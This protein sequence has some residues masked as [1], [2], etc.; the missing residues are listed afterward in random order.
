MANYK[1]NIGK[2]RD[3]NNRKKIDKTIWRN[4][5][6]LGY[7]YICS[8]QKNNQTIKSVLT[9]ESHDS[10][11]DGIWLVISDTNVPL[12]KILMEAKYRSDYEK[13]LPLS[14]CAKAIIIAFNM[15]ANKLYIVTN[16]AFAPQTRSEISQF[17]RRSNL[18]VI[19][20]NQTELRCFISDNRDDLIKKF[21][22]DEQFLNELEMDD[23]PKISIPDTVLNDVSKSYLFDECRK[24]LI[25]E[26]AKKLMSERAVYM[27]TGQ[28]GIGKSILGKEIEKRLLK[29]KYDV[30]KI[31]LSLCTSARVLYLK[32]LEAI[33]GVSLTT[34]LEDIDLATYLDQLISTSS[35]TIEPA[36]VNAIK[37]ILTSRV[38][39]AEHKDIFLYLLLK[40]IDCILENKKD[41]LNLAIFFENINM[42]SEEVSDFLLELINCLRKNNIK[43]LLEV[44]TPFIFVDNSNLTKSNWYF[45]SLKKSVDDY[46]DVKVLESKTAIQM[47]QKQLLLSDRVCSNMAKTLDN[48]PL[49]IQSALK[50]LSADESLLNANL[51]NMSDEQ[52]E[53]YW[54]ECGISLNSVVS[55][56]ILKLRNDPTLSYAFEMVTL[57]KGSIPYYVLN[58]IDKEHKDHFIKAIEDSTIFKEGRAAFECFHLRYLTAMEETSELRKKYE[59]ALWLLPIVRENKNAN[60]LNSYI[61]LNLLY[62]LGMDE[63][64]PSYTLSVIALLKE[65]HQYKDAIKVANKYIELQDAKT[66]IDTENNKVMIDVLIQTLSCVKELDE[67]NNPAYSF[68]YKKAC[69]YIMLDNPDTETAGRN[70]YQFRLLLWF[71]EF[72]IGHFDEAM[73]IAKSLYDQIEK[74]SG[75]FREDED[76]PGQVYN[77]YG[78]SVK[79]KNSGDAAEQIFRE[80][81]SRYPKSFFGRA[82]LLSQVGNRLL[83]TEPLLAAQI[84]ADLL[85]TIKG[86]DYPYQECLHTRIDIAMSNF[87]GEKYNIACMRCK[88]SVEIASTI[89]IYTQKGRALNIWGCCLAAQGDYEKSESLFRESY[90]LLVLSNAINYSWRSRMNLA[91]IL[92]YQ[93]RIDDAVAEFEAVLNTLIDSF[94]E[95][96]VRDQDSVPYQC[97]LVILLYLNETQNTKKIKQILEKLDLD[98]LNR[99]F[100]RLS[101][102]Q[103]W[104]ETFHSKVAFR[105]DVILV[106]G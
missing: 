5:E 84:Y 15:S 70:W 63:L 74:T 3:K 31:D 89:G 17:N 100:L 49:E 80:C 39:Y 41:W 37:H 90:N 86:K 43:V 47:I 38:S 21:E 99:D 34:I 72:K 32:I 56:L 98:I 59:V 65:C 91:T 14:D 33:W 42:V 57:L 9:N 54:N 92:L 73:D 26:I 11:Y 48:N 8:L 52:L 23:S 69:E 24:N 78:L 55:S 68:L 62:A 6:K 76:Y 20:V 45:N 75:L 94:R 12:Q 67:D 93:Q 10:G 106:T 27:L 97:I 87:L 58:E 18:Q 79:V 61:E 83:R 85:E 82:A 19:G 7:A 77:T 29:E 35:L 95:K 104:R 71:K 96:I 25:T 66:Q 4:L 28:E 22:I 30:F 64:I 40:Y 88:E 46:F 36:V 2:K 50:I 44:R 81:V 1:R 103:H 51:E 101:D 60:P 105:G 102:L 16:K 53:E 13:S